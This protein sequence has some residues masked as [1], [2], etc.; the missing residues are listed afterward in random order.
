MRCVWDCTGGIFRAGAKALSVP[1][2]SSEAMDVL[3]RCAQDGGSDGN[4]LGVVTPLTPLTPSPSSEGEVAH[5]TEPAP[6]TK[7][8]AEEGAGA[9]AEEQRALVFGAQYQTI[10]AAMALALVAE[11][12]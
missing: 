2:S 3:R 8:A 6:G 7:A 4:Q 9:G 5:T 12:R 10:N 1:Q 11:V